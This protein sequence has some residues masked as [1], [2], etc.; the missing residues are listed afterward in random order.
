MH[1]TLTPLAAPKAQSGKEDGPGC[2]HSPCPGFSHSCS[3]LLERLETEGG[4]PS[5][6]LHAAKI[7][8]LLP[9][10][11]ESRFQGQPAVYASCS[12]FWGPWGSGSGINCLFTFSTTLAFPFELCLAFARQE[13]VFLYVF[14][15]FVA[16]YKTVLFSYFASFSC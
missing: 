5:R 14:F 3:C 12:Q 10:K 8:G 1:V 2:C 13:G 16:A 11:K 4:P 6:L 9:Q 7:Q 15:S